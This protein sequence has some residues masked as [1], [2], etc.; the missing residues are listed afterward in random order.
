MTGAAAMP[1]RDRLVAAAQA[2]IKARAQLDQAKETSARA[3][4]FVGELERELDG[5]RAADTADVEANSDDI[6]SALK[7]GH[8]PVFAASPALSARALALRDAERRLAAARRATDALAVER[9]QAGVALADA[10]AK[11]AIAVHGVVVGEAETIA[12]RIQ[13]LETDA[14]A[15]RVQTRRPAWSTRAT[16]RAGRAA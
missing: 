12:E 11:H 9:K 16:K 2:K 1:P 5:L 10:E 14:Q 3:A 8:A 7:S 15:L 6:L 4:R 13:A